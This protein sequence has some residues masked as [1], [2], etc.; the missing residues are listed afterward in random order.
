MGIKACQKLFVIHYLFQEKGIS[1][2]I[3]VKLF[4]FYEENTNIFVVFKIWW[5]FTLTLR[6]IF[7]FILSTNCSIFYWCWKNRF[8]FVWK[9]IYQT[10]WKIFKSKVYLGKILLD[11]KWGEQIIMIFRATNTIA[12][13][14]QS[15]FSTIKNTLDTYR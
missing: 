1:E 6:F 11:R 9:D 5:H 7:Y 13:Q 12:H 10:E 14:A 15:L 8:G 4:P 2:L 3:K